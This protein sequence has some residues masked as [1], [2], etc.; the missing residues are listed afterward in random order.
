[1]MARILV[2]TNDRRT[3]LDEADVHPSS[4]R[5]EHV[6]GDLLGRLE[7]AV[8]RAERASRTRRGDLNRRP[9]RSLAGERP[10]RRLLA[11]MPARDY[12]EVYH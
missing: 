3:I 5:D 7:R 11:I 12:R 4:I 10:V 1:M 9:G 2:Q 6:A 8:T